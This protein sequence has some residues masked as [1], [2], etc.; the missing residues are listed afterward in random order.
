MNPNE[1]VS[2][3]LTLLASVLSISL[4]FIGG[5]F[6]YKHESSLG[7]AKE[8]S[9]AATNCRAEIYQRPV[10]TWLADSSPN[11]C[12]SQL[13]A[14]DEY[15]GYASTGFKSARD[16]LD[17]ARLFFWIWVIAAIVIATLFYGIRWALTG[18]VKPFFPLSK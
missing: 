15:S 14:C 3:R 12:S 5:Y 17:K 13:A 10:C 7:Y 2:F 9:M 1:I 16:Y 18:K 8:F 11:G 4:L 6:Y